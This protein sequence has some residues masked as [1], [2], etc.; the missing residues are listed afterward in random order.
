MKNIKKII[1]NFL[2]IVLIQVEMYFKE[3]IHIIKWKKINKD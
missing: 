2:M 3:N 1:I